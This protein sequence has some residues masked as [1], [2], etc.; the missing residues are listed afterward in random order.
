MSE[1]GAV[2]Q[3]LGQSKATV[4]AIAN[5]KGGVGK[6][7]TAINLACSFAGTRRKVLLIDLDPQ[8]ST[9]VSIMRKRPT[10][11]LSTGNALMQGSSLVPC[12]Y[13]YKISRFD[14]LPASDDLTAFAVSMCQVPGAEHCLKQA[15]E[16][17]KEMYD[18]IIIDCPPSLNLLTSN[19]LCAAEQF[20]V[21]TTCEF[22]AV[23]G[24]HSLL[25]QFETLKR[26]GRS[27]I[28]FMGIVRTMFDREQVLAQ[29][30]SHELCQNFG[31]L[32]FTTII[33]YTSRISEAPSLGRPVL[34]YD[35][36]SIGAKAYLSLAGEVLS[37]LEH[38][39]ISPE[40]QRFIDSF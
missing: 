24:L 15:I 9:T 5:H 2:M 8:G 21:P 29:R 14:I 11:V 32:I 1:C 40:Y 25:R 39:I 27:S 37:R 6:T 36:S 18:L 23:Q 22:F 35:K 20:I 10:G 16:P 30:I 13:P 38:P 28:N 12:I 34:L 4:I 3:G 33:P 26:E 7:S 19:A 17:L 31:K